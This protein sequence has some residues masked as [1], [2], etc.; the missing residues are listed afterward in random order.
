MRDQYELVRVRLAEAEVA[1]R[2]R[3][4][5]K[6]GQFSLLQRATATEAISVV[7]NW[8]LAGVAG[9]LLLAVAVAF[10]LDRRYPG[11]PGGPWAG[12]VYRL[13]DDPA[14]PVWGVPRYMCSTAF[15]VVGMVGLAALLR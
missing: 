3:A 1:A 15:V 13:L 9:S 2:N 4:S 14:R 11:V 10:V 8:M 12:R 5:E 7:Q 6:A